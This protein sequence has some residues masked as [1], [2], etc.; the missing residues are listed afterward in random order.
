MK[1]KKAV[2]TANLVDESF[3]E[4]NERIMKEIAD[5]FREDAISIPWVKSVEGITVKE[6]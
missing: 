2:I 1:R 6:Q 3:E 5:W 4:S